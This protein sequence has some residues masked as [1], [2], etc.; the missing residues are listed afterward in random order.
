M[1]KIHTR[2]YGIA[3]EASIEISLNSLHKILKE[4]NVGD[5]LAL[6]K[7]EVIDLLKEDNELVKVLL[8]SIAKLIEK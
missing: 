7:L 1:L 2:G 6:I 8:K 5:R 4:S 3:D